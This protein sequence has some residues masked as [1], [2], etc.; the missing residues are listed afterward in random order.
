MIVLTV[1]L[2]VNGRAKKIQIDSLTP[3]DFTTGAAHIQQEYLEPISEILMQAYRQL[4]DEG[5]A[6]PMLRNELE[7]RA[8]ISRRLAQLGMV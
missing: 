1:F 2:E 5:N 6:D 8:S 7:E 3:G 4:S